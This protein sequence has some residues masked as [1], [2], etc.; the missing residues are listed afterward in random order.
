V[1]AAPAGVALLAAGKLTL[2]RGDDHVA[3]ES[4]FLLTWVA[5]A[6][7]GALIV[8]RRPRHP[9]GWLFCAMGLSTAAQE[10]LLGYG[11][12]ADLPGATAA[13]W[14]S[15][16]AS[17]PT[18]VLVLV[19]LLV[20]PTG[21]FISRGWR[22]VGLAAVAVAALWAVALALD[23]GD[24]RGLEGVANPLGVDAASGPLGFAASALVVPFMLCGA[25][26]VT[27]AIVRF[28]R[29]RGVERE[30][31]KWLALAAGALLLAVLSVVVLLLLVD[32]DSGVWDVVTALL[33]CLGL[34]AFPAAAGI[35]ILRHRLYDIDLVIR[36][37]LVYG[38]LTATLLGVYLGL[39]LLV[40]LTVGDSDAAVAASTLAVA[41]LFR[42]ART[43][44][45]AI[46]DRRFYR[47]RYDAARTLEA[48]AGG[49]RDQ[50]DLEAL[51]RDLRE[52]VGRTMQPT[53]VSVWLRTRR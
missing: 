37:T 34:A 36:R 30:Q 8:S 32:T 13:A 14:L 3:V 38:A 19:L 9:V 28:R 23:P 25:L 35:A 10:F 12:R 22:R 5:Y 50:V 11:G 41:W 27:G 49:L 42:P 31:T 46:V 51:S 2:I 16:W 26:A 20:F 6:T 39:V 21:R 53:H 29:A 43:R 18:T 40:G 44:I 4:L 1:W 17:E 52:V 7:V 24:L 33:V 45:Q 15:S 48:F 47:R